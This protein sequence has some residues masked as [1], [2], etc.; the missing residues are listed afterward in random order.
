VTNVTHFTHGWHHCSF[1]SWCPP[2]FVPVPGPVTVIEGGTTI[3]ETPAIVQ[4]EVVQAAPIAYQYEKLLVV[5]NDTKEEVQFFI[6]YHTV[7]GGWAPSS[8]DKVEQVVAV[9]LKPGEAYILNDG[10]KHLSANKIRIWAKSATKE[11]R[12]HFAS[13]LWLVDLDASGQ[14]RYPGE[15]MDIYAFQLK[16]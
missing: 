8:P 13:D 1:I 10:M 16:E 2:I 14:R 7:A 9:G 4:T 3:V 11:W 12:D 6:L 5:K 15:E